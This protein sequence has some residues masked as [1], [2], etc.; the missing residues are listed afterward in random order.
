MHP[1]RVVYLQI[2]SRGSY[3][4][5]RVSILMPCDFKVWTPSWTGWLAGWHMASMSCDS[6]GGMAT[7]AWVHECMWAET[8]YLVSTVLR[9]QSAVFFTVFLKVSEVVLI[10]S[11]THQQIW[12]GLLIRTPESCVVVCFVGNRRCN[13]PQKRYDT[14]S[15]S[16]CLESCGIRPMHSCAKAPRKATFPKYLGQSRQYDKNIIILEIERTLLIHDY[17]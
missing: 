3:D 17:Y 11:K 9:S 8:S 7:S 5:S 14:D 16:L 2:Q 6:F 4:V 12:L 15:S 10:Y 1:N 13:S